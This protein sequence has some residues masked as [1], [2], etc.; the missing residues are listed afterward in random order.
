MAQFSPTISNFLKE[1]STKKSV[2][3]SEQQDISTIVARIPRLTSRFRPGEIIIFNYTALNQMRD[4]RGRFSGGTERVVL[5]VSSKREPHGIRRTRTT[6]GVIVACFRLEYS[7]KAV[8][9]IVLKTLYKSRKKLK[10]IPKK[11]KEGLFAVL[12][13]GV[14][15]TY[16]LDRMEFCWNLNLTEAQRAIINKEEEEQENA[17]S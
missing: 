16:R 7:S 17:R 12:G 4:T 5:V 14:Y 9:D 6:G 3:F 10:N 1:Y 8:I 2:V 15:R 11:V 13:K